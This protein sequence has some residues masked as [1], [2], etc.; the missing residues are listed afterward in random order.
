MNPRMCRG[1]IDLGSTSVSSIQIGV[2]QYHATFAHHNT[3]VTVSQYTLD[4]DTL[5]DMADYGFHYINRL[6][7]L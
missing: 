5:H 2:E 4:I 1:V 7:Y 3:I 6:I